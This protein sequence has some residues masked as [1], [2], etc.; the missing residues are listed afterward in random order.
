MAA[1]AA[2]ETSSG[3]EGDDRRDIPE[4]CR[5][6]LLSPFD[7]HFSQ[8]RVREEFQDKRF[9][10]D[11]IK[12]IE[13]IPMSEAGDIA[14]EEEPSRFDGEFADGD[15]V[16]LRLPFPR[17]EVT[18]WRCK[19]READG[20]PRLDPATGL[21]LYSR[22]EHFFSF[23]NRRLVCL[24]KAAAKSW[25]SKVRCEVI[26]I[27]GHLAKFRELRKFDTRT[28][29]LSVTVGRRDEPNLE[30]WC[31]RTAVG[32][33]EEAQ[34]EGGVARQRGVRWRGRQGARGAESGRTGH[35]QDTD[36]A[37]GI[38][39]DFVRSVLLFLLIYLALRI[40]VLAFSHH[41]GDSGD[42]LGALPINDAVAGPSGADPSY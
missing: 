26:E 2:E 16:L 19:L 3:A 20:S 6:I 22:E 35:R 14:S 41:R 36:G 28:F 10:V 8:T 38:S 37:Q 9:L 18:K 33:P 15:G 34:P 24:Q 32:L 29:G 5:V 31:W 42:G 11:A 40:A 12:E 13:A 23:D 7:I 21:E 30:T 27:P 4:G 17:I 1:A 25:P 39:I